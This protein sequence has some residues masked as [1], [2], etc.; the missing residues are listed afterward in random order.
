[1]I[2][3]VSGDVLSS[4]H[5]SVMRHVLNKRVAPAPR[6]NALYALLNK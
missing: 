5:D 3:V 2:G 1:M 4:Y 6:H